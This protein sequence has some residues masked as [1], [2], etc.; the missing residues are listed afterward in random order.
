[1]YL[2]SQ[3]VNGYS[4]DAP[5]VDGYPN[6][7]A[8]YKT[9]LKMQ[10][11]AFRNYFFPK[12][13]N[14]FNNQF[15]SGGYNKRPTFFG[16]DMPEG[17]LIVYLPNYFATDRTDMQTMQTD[18]TG[19]ELDGFFRNSLLIATQKNSTLNDPEW[20][21]CLACALIDKQQKRSNKPRTAQC[22]NCFRK[23]CG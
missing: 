15:I 23:Y 3:T 5:D 19:D 2:Y 1:M 8:L 18:F 9:Y 16:C 12:I 22:K 10:Q 21:E 13:P 14:T 7:T 6:G 4:F 17:P 11:P 20:P